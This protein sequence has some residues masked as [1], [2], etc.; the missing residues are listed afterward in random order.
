MHPD[1]D[2]GTEP[3]KGWLR[4]DDKNA[5][6]L[7]A[8]AALAFL[9]GIHV[10]LREAPLTKARMALAKQG[11]DDLTTGSIVFLPIQGDRCR[12]RL[13]DNATWR[14]RDT[15]MVDCRTALSHSS[16]RPRWSAARADVI[17]DGFTKR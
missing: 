15:G 8:A 11:V 9:G 16:A 13:I 14:I 3:S 17:R 10:V 5:L 6:L 4:R 2:T 1:L 12:N 7:C